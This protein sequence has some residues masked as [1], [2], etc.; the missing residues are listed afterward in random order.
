M[1]VKSEPLAK[2]KDIKRVSD[3]FKKFFH[4]LFLYI[5]LILVG[6]V[7]AA[8]YFRTNSKIPQIEIFKAGEVSVSLN[9]KS[10]L[11]FIHRD[12]GQPLLVD[13]TLTEIINN[14]LAARD[15]VRVNTLR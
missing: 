13:S 2:N 5:A 8:F 14:M 1:E 15:Y 11:V 10:E 7:V 9:E 3:S 12:K 4:N 6:I